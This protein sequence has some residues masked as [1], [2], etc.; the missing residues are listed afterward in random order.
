MS[1]TNIRNHLSF[2]LN[3]VV[4]GSCPTTGRGRAPP[5]AEGPHILVQEGESSRNP[6]NPRETLPFRANPWETSW[7]ELPRSAESAG[8]RVWFA[9]TSV[10]SRA[11]THPDI[12][13]EEDKMNPRTECSRKNENAESGA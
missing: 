10:I 3:Q 13:Y 12:P 6:R 1:V 11:K 5:G 2:G 8:S 7:T 4:V 9:A